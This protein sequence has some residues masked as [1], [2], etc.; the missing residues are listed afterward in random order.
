MSLE[1]ATEYLRRYDLEKKII[2]K[3]EST[4]TVE[5]AA[6]ALNTEPERIAKTL[7]FFTDKPILIVMA[8]NSKIDNH[9]Y[10]SFFKKKA[11]MLSGEEVS[12]MIGHDVGGVC[13]FGVNDGVDIYLDESLK[14]FT[15]VFPAVGNAH[16]AI[17]LTPDE[18]ERITEC[19]GW[20]DVTKES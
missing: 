14:K 17:E 4:A 19:I 11:K 13:P 18:L 6:R 7:S 20:V 15:T 1:K 16:S 3:E 12:S 8:G 10:K 5:E 2:I 9:K